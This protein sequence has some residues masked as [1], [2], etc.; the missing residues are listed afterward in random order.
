MAKVVKQAQ[1]AVA[2]ELLDALRHEERRRILKIA[3]DS[4]RPL[5][6]SMASEELSAPLRSTSKHF[7]ALLAA[8]LL[9]LV[10]EVPVRG[11]TEH[12]YLPAGDVLAHPIVQAVLLCM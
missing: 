4:G 5:S 7:K 6:P 3:V 9:V 10:T 11:A 8:G 1:G 2:Q 12:F